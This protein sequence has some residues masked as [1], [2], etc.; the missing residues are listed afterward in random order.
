[1][2]QKISDSLQTYVECFSNIESNINELCETVSEDVEFKDPFNHVY[3]K[4]DFKKVMQHF[5]QNSKNAHF[6]VNPYHIEYSE[7]GGQTILHWTFTAHIKIIGDWKFEGMSLVH[8]NKEGLICKHID[9]WD[10][11]EHFYKHIPVI[12]YFIKKII[13]RVKIHE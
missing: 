13:K 3:N 9:F 2:N 5:V 4:Q 11:G 12:G 6:A 10:S 1:M 7:E 8:V